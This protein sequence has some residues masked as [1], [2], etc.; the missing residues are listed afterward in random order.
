MWSSLCCRAGATSSDL[1]ERAEEKIESEGAAPPTK[2]E[3][4]TEQ[5]TSEQD[6]FEEYESEYRLR[7][8]SS[9]TTELEK[10]R[11]KTKT[12]SVLDNESPQASSKIRVISNPG[13][14]DSSET[15]YKTARPSSLYSLPQDHHPSLQSLLIKM[16]ETEQQRQIQHTEMISMMKENFEALFKEIRDSKERKFSTTNSMR[17]ERSGDVSP[18]IGES[19]LPQHI[20]VSEHVILRLSER[21]T[22]KWKFLARQLGMEEHEIQKI[23]GD[24][25]GDTQEQSYQMLLKWTQSQ[26]EEGSYQTLGDAI[27]TIFGEK[28]Y[29]KYVKIVLNSEE[30]PMILTPHTQ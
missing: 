6:P 7:P 21:V 1:T 20:P 10:S 25:Q 14:L 13:A 8:M 18:F 28:L 9:S 29:S 11:H 24:N 12:T 4:K 16:K 2:L 30:G 15:A 17:S 19:M 23:A 22:A 3:S 5:K 26:G 27:K